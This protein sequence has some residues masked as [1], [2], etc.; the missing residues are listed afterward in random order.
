[1]QQREKY[2][3]GGKK[4]P[5]KTSDNFQ[6]LHHIRQ[7]WSPRFQ[8]FLRLPQVLYLLLPSQELITFSQPKHDSAVTANP[9]PTLPVLSGDVSGVWEVHFKADQLSYLL[10]I[11]SYNSFHFF[12]SDFT[13]RH[14]GIPIRVSTLK[15]PATY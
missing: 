7:E 1:M 4:M 2:Q 9:L 12:P 11:S 8:C 5:R 15:I 3:F 6:P 13:F 14:K 10:I